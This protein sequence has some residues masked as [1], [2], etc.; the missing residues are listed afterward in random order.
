MAPW[1]HVG[2]GA[3]VTWPGWLHAMA[4]EAEIAHLRLPAVGVGQVPQGDERVLA[5]EGLLEADARLLALILQHVLAFCAAGGQVRAPGPPVPRSPRQGT[6][7]L[8]VLL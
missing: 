3:A 6:H 7:H 5:L 2:E 1:V 4:Q 8:V